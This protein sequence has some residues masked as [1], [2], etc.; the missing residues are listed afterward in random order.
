MKHNL[1]MHPDIHATAFIAAGSIVL[2]S[3][4]IGREC[5]VLYHAVVRGDTEEIIVGDESNIQDLCCLHADPG[6][7]CRIGQR[8]SIGHGAIVHGATIEDEVLI[9]MRAVVMNGSHVGQGSIIGAGAV[10]LEGTTIPPHSLVLGMPGV[11]RR[12]TTDHD[13]VRILRA[14]ENYRALVPER[15][16]YQEQQRHENS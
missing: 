9:G 13:R 10:V 15:R 11:V 3:V 16:R 6:F 8:V 12:S 5:S 1:L 14:A 2:G 7:P 4:R